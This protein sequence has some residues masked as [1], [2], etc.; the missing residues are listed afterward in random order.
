M[1]RD[2]VYFVKIEM[3][4][5]LPVDV[6]HLM[7][8]YYFVQQ[9]FGRGSNRVIPTLERWIPGC[10]ANLIV[11]TYTNKL[12]DVNIYTKFGELRPDELLGVFK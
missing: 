7:S 5:T 11:P 8:L 3:R 1:D 4:K 9:F 10:G 6:N 12:K 2:Y